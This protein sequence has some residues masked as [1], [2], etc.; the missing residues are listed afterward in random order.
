MRREVDLT[1]ETLGAECEAQVRNEDFDR[2]LSIVFEVAR[3]VYRGHGPVTELALDLVAVSE[4]GF[5]AIERGGHASGESGVSAGQLYG[6][7]R[8]HA[9]LNTDA[10]DWNTDA[11]DQS[12]ETTRGIRQHQSIRVE[13]FVVGLGSRSRYSIEIG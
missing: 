4:G 2:D 6:C 12:T 8:V 10:S 5:Y 1:A 7:S 11:P 13:L 9:R 3:Q